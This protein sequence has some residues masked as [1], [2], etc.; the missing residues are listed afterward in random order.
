VEILIQD[1]RYGLRMLRKNP[2]FTA[3]AVITLA[4]GIGANTAIFSAVNGVLLRPLPFKQPDRLVK[5]WPGKYQTSVSKAEFVELKSQSQSFDDLAAFSGW[6]FTLTGSGE[7]AKLNGV[8]TTADFFSLLGANA[9]LG[10]VFLPDEDQPAQSRVAILGHGLW[11]RRFGSDPEII[12]QTIT[13]DG[14]SHT[15]VGVMAADFEFPDPEFPKLDLDLILPAPIDPS[16]KDFTANYLNVIARLKQGVTPEQAQTEVST[17]ARAAREKFPRTPDNYG[18]NAAVA[19]FQKEATG[20]IRPTLLMLLA[21]VGAVL[22]IACANVANLQ[23]AR[24]AGRRKEIA[25]RAALGA[26]RRQIIRQ[27]LTESLMLAMLGGA[28]GLLV[29]FWAARLLINL[30]PP[31]APR[32]NDI[33]IDGSVL[34]FSLLISFLTGALFGLAPAFQF[35]KP[36]LQAALKEGGGK[37][38]SISGG[39]LRSLLVVSEVALALMLVISAG[40]MIKSFWL[41]YR[42]SPGFDSANVLSLQLAP[43]STQYADNNRMRAFY[44]EAIERIAALPGVESVGGIHL[45]PMGGSN[46]N[47]GLKV[48]DHPLPAGSALPSVDWR[49]ITPDYFRAMKIPLLRGRYFDE[50][51]NERGAT[52]AIINETLARQYWPDE[53][54]IGKR[55]STGFEQ[56]QWV[57]IVGVVGDVKHHGLDSKTRLEMYRCYDQSPFIPYMTLMARTTS[58]PVTLASAIRSEVWA[59]DPNVP[60]AEVQPLTEVVSRSLTKPRSTT[61]MLAAFAGIALA[62]GAV[63]IYGTLAYSVSQRTREI[64]IR[65]ALGA[66]RRDTMRLVMGQGLRLTLAGIAIGLAGSYAATRALASLLFGVSSTDFSTFATVSLLLTAVAMI[67]CFIPARRAMNVDPCAALRCE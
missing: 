44:H 33:A 18:L 60:V 63:G 14:E 17:I 49:L 34:G 32:L 12:G 2:G 9:A 4:L 26:S 27:M 37:S 3:V 15:V 13:I 46:W 54:P 40:L 10:R 5:V 8:R 29:A 58:D 52:V 36:D 28:T 42:V 59:V 57:S 66:N 41:M 56:N 51:D 43:P 30:L 6:G 47:P 61:L 22:L 67:A 50:S 7:P 21:A 38:T 35:S 53:D 11:E 23:L 1:L 48:E 24:A 31:D 65:M 20:D 16:S 55:I 64:G 39:R 19:S 45:L 62:L 25:I